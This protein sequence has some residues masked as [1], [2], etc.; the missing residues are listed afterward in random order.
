MLDS[1]RRVLDLGTGAGGFSECRRC[2]TTVEPP[3]AGCPSCGSE[4]IAE[5]DI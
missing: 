1:L 3:A 5:Y 4:E 2:G